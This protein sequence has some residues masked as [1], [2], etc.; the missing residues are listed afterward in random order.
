[1]DEQ[2]FEATADPQEIAGRLG[3]EIVQ[4]FEGALYA[5]D[6]H[7]L[8]EIGPVSATDPRLRVRQAW[9]HSSDYVGEEYHTP[10]EGASHAGLT[11]IEERS[12]G[13]VIALDGFGRK[14]VV[15]KTGN[16]P[17]ASG[18][19]WATADEMRQWAPQHQP[20]RPTTT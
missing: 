14:F 20:S 4:W 19:G 9:S 17:M 8:Y 6:E 5:R 13:D 2:I 12:S 15:S 18:F 7:Q 10:R 16:G 1:M 3:L 11:V